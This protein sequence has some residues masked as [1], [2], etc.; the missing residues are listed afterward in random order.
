MMRIREMVGLGNG[1]GEKPTP[2]QFFGILRELGTPR[3]FGT[4]SLELPGSS[5]FSRGRTPTTPVIFT[6]LH[7]T[8]T[9]LEHFHK[10]DTT[11]HNY[12]SFCK[13]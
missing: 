3:K 2:V 12:W 4:L 10:A 7:Y 5:T 8:L 1:E 11:L 9:N 6:L 13:L